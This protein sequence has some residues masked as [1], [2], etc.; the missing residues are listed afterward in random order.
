M[1]DT[2]LARLHRAPGLVPISLMIAGMFVL[3]HVLDGFHLYLVSLAVATAVAAMGLNLLW[4]Y[5]GILSIG[6][7]GF[8]AMGAYVPV[9]AMDRWDWPFLP[10]VGLAIFAGVVL[11]V[12]LAVP[13]GRL[14]GLGLGLVTF[15]MAYAVDALLRGNYL[16]DY[17]NGQSGLFVPT[18]SVLGIDLKGDTTMW[19]VAAGIFVLASLATNMLVNSGM[20]REIQA[21][22]ANVHL[23]TAFG[24]RTRR[25]SAMIFV[26]AGIYGILSGVLLA[27]IVRFVAPDVAPASLSIELLAMVLVGGGGTLL[28]PLFGAVFF[29]LLPEF[30]HWARDNSGVV[31]A[32]A[33][34]LTLIF[35]PSGFMGVLDRVRL[36]VQQTPIFS[37]S[38][39]DITRRRRKTD[40]PPAAVE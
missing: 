39:G 32:S 9:I 31:F 30:V 11:A 22:R 15:G 18:S 17:T 36:A 38:F 37:K 35:A 19:Y 8:V 26:I 29:I 1:S 13:G 6:H 16:L 40:I 7:S 28:G 14:G 5:A 23:A 10:A 25:V 34:M 24:V 3:P 4:G 12:L 20:G 2:S 21:M 27:Q 33:L